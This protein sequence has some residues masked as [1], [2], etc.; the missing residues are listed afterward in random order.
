[1]KKRC[2]ADGRV[3]THALGELQARGTLFVRPQEDT[4][5]GMVIGESTRDADM[6]VTASSW[7]LSVLCSLLNLGPYGS[8]GRECQPLIR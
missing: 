8:E 4:Y 2:C 3:T 6:E 1:M 7:R 5:N